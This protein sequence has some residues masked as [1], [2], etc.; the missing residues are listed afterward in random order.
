ME[1]IT[2]T[3]VEPGAFKDAR[4]GSFLYAFCSNHAEGVCNWLVPHSEPGRLCK[5]CNHNRTIPNLAVPANSVAWYELER[6]KKHLVYSI[7]RLGLPLDG[8]LV[9]RGR[10][11]FDFV[12]QAGITHFDG[13]ITIDVAE[14]DPVERER[15]RQILDEPY[16][17][18]LGHLRHESGHFYWMLLIEGGGQLEPFRA[19]F[20]DERADYLASLTR[21][22]ADGPPADWQLKHVSAYASSHPWEDW[23]ETWAH[24]LHIVDGLDTAEAQGIAPLASR[25]PNGHD[26]APFRSA[27]DAVDFAAVVADWI[28]L[29]VGMNE[30]S[31]SIGHPDYYPFVL[32]E[33]SI[34]KLC[35]VHQVIG[36][37]KRKFAQQ[38]Q[39]T[40]AQQPAAPMLEPAA[41]LP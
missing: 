39:A 15:Q 40:Q 22:R 31:R 18:I 12:E 14:V 2:L 23:A 17:S 20:G 8:A 11:I 1:M 13:V 35:F 34:E 41:P 7:M 28:D 9:G 32:S 3:E 4:G 24:Y 19:L 5:A 38:P 36:A 10:M 27:Y 21:F 16:R 37:F 26:V 25:Q 33:T 6:A 30:M 29:S